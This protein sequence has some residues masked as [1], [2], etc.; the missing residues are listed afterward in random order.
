MTVTVAVALLTGSSSPRL[1]AHRGPAH[2]CAHSSACLMGRHGSGHWGR[3]STSSSFQRQSD[4][5]AP[6]TAP[7]GKQGDRQG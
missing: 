5:S 1:L 4:G 7:T 6:D 3:G 2:R